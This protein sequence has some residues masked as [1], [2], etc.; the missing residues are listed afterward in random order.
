[1]LEVAD[2]ARL[3]AS[4]QALVEAWNREAADPEPTESP[5]PTLRLTQESVDGRVM[6]TLSLVPVGG[7]TATEI[8]HGLFADGY[9]LLGP[10]KALLLEAVAQRAA[11][12]RLSASQA[13][14]DLLPRDGQAH[15][16]A[17]VWQNLGGSLG[18]IAELVHRAMPEMHTGE[19]STDAPDAGSLTE[20]VGDGGPGLAVAYADGREISF[21]T[22]GLRGPLGLSFESLLAIGGLFRGDVEPEGASPAPE[23]SASEPGDS[24]PGGNPDP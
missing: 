15:A 21:V 24:P 19:S 9:L 1:M 12:V 6:F 7:G 11:G 18:S 13:F 20:L 10:S 3:H 2:A 5:R 17:L 4:V 23:E 22:R 16:S 8:A 14:L